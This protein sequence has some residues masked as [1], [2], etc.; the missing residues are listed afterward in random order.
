MAKTKALPEEKEPEKKDE[1]S[2]LTFTEEE[3][4]NLVDYMNF[5]SSHAKFDGLSMKQM[6][7]F[8]MTNVKAI[9]VVRKIES[10]IFEFKRK[11]K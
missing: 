8:S 3:H 11:F 4:K 5:V 9:G 1:V 7:E 10:H 6:H 2:Q